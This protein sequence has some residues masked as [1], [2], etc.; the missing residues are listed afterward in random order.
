MISRRNA[1][2][3]LV[4]LPIALALG[5]SK[6]EGTAAGPAGSGSAAPATG[7]V[8]LVGAGATFPY[9]LYSK[10]MSEYNK[11]NPNVRINYQS[12]GSGGGIRQVSAGT[13][14]FGAS[15]AP[16]TAD[17]VQKAPAKLHHI[18]STLGAVII[19]YNVP[20]V[21]GPLKLSAEAVSGIFL[22]TIKKWNDPKLVEANSDAKLPDKDIAVVYRSDG[23]GTTAVFTDYLVKVSPEFKD[24]VGAGKSVKWPVGLGAKG[25]E[26][27]T[28]QVK[29]TPFTVGYVEL[30]YARQNKL[31][32]AHVKNKAGKF[33]EPK[34]ES[35][36]A[37]AAGVEVDDTLTAS[38]ADPPG[39][40]AYP[41]SAF[42]YLLVYED[43]KN[44]VKGEAI[45]KFLWWALHDGQKHAAELDYAPLPESLIKKTEERIKSLRSGN[46]KLLSGG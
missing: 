33:V 27:V 7:Q 12:I 14:D 15:D 40:A 42:T 37:A 17:E 34:P 36:T 16:M 45:A 13:V 31:P 8:T 41:I 11:V 44:K 28:G 22:G 1:V 5:C 2:S 29:T 20:G 10:W 39:E 38:L 23:S 18:P 26:G 6:T 43:A 21:S 4:C 9:P 24:K 3:V 32:I 46:E 35:I 19:T 25:N 30:A